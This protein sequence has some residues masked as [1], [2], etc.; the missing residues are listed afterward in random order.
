MTTTPPKPLR[1]RRSD[2]PV[3]SRPFVALV[4]LTLSREEELMIDRYRATAPKWRPEIVDFANMLA[5]MYP[6]V[7]KARTLAPTRIRLAA[8]EGK[9]VPE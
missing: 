5:K 6:L 4:P 3:L 7:K 2:R 9:K 1:T 8:A